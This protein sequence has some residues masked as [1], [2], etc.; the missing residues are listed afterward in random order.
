MKIEKKR[1]LRERYRSSILSMA[2]IVLVFI[3]IQSSSGQNYYPNYPRTVFWHFG[4]ATP[5]WYARF[6]LV[7][8]ST[9]NVEWVQKVKAINSDAIILST[10]GWTAWGS[11]DEWF[12][13]ETNPNYFFVDSNGNFV[14]G[15]T[16]GYMT[17]ISNLCPTYNG[18]RF[19]ERFPEYL[20]EITDLNYFDGIAS[21]WLWEK[22]WGVTDIDMD[23]NGVNDYT[24]YGKPWVDSVFI[25][26]TETLLENMRNAMPADK[27][28]LVN[29]GWFHVYGET[30]T[31]G[32]MIEHGTGFVSYDYLWSRYQQ[33]MRDYP[34]PHVLLMVSNGNAS[35]PNLP[36]KPKNYFKLMRGMLAWMMLGDGY[37]SF[38]DLAAAE[39]TYNYW[40]DEFDLDIGQPT[41]DAYKLSNGCYIRFF[42]QGAVI[43]NPTGVTQTVSDADLA[44][45]SGY[46]GPYYRFLGGQDPDCNDG[47][48]FNQV[49]LWGDV[50]EHLS[51]GDGIILTTERVI[52][53]SDIVVDNVNPATSP[54]S[55]PAVFTGTWTSTNDVSSTYFVS[56]KYWVNHWEAA[57]AN[58][59]SGSNK[60]T[61][62]PTITRNGRYEV[63]EWHGSYA[64]TATNVPY[65]ITY[66]GGA[67]V[68]GTI[69]QTINIG[70]W[71]SLG[72][73]QFDAGTTG[74][75]EMNNNANGIVVA[76]AVKFVARDIGYDV[77][78]PQ[79]PQGVEVIQL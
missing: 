72:V 3:S 26:G 6:D 71:N 58:A 7:V 75:F 28:L 37:Y 67:T 66:A 33:F 45:V 23:R 54:G 20:V 51:F 65:T 16:G 17:D 56:N 10:S 53:I 9:R 78:A 64:G 59:G 68:T 41:T 47:S 29:S 40:Y 74:N 50:W 70:Q 21:D 11:G 12:P 2:V 69:D 5:E 18:K 13:P 30:T 55:D 44:A 57:I 27:V 36:E 35:D 39:Y 31:N 15:G 76:D 42:D 77:V 46:D 43:V 8:K 14:D 61:F 22:P 52:A 24:E 48:E 79:P 32:L 4:S 62:T 49:E 25:A 73:Y 19:N 63:F 60:A 34:E 38:M 1:N